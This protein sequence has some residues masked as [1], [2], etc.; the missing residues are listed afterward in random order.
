MTYEQR[1]SLEL[2]RIIYFYVNFKKLLKSNATGNFARLNALMNQRYL[3]TITVLLLVWLAS[4][5]VFALDTYHGEHQQMGCQ[6]KETLSGCHVDSLE[7]DHNDSESRNIFFQ[8]HAS[9]HCVVFC[10]SVSMTYLQAYP[11]YETH[12][13]VSLEL[14]FFIPVSFIRTPYRPPIRL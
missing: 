6:Q 3:R 4:Q 13:L 8:E 12:S 9:D 10:Q 7:R 14:S 1:L 11:F 5:Q 2:P